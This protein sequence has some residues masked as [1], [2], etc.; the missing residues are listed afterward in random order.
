M[1]VCEFCADVYHALRFLWRDSSLVVAGV[2]LLKLI[3]TY[4]N[5]NAIAINQRIVKYQLLLNYSSLMTR[6]ELFVT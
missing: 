6:N 3:D 2:I 5:T 1:S 4:T